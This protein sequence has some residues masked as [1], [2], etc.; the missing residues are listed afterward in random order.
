MKIGYLMQAGVPDVRRY[1]LS[2]PANHVAQVF[3]ELAKL[4]HHLRLL[5]VLDHRIWKS[6]DLRSFAPVTVGWADHR[7][8]RSFERG[9][10]RIQSELR[11]PYAALFEGVRFALACRQELSG[12]DLLYER[13]GWVGYG[14]SLAAQWLQ[15]PLILE[16]NGDHLTELERRGIAP[17]G[18]Q[19]RLSIAL[20]KSVTRRASHT[21]ATGEGHR[22]Q[23]IKRWSVD[24]HKLTVVD[25]GSEL[26]HLLSRSQ[27]HA[28]NVNAKG[29]G[30][31]TIAYSGGF[32]PWQ[33][34]TILLRAVQRTIAAGISVRLL[35][36]GSGPGVRDAA[37]MV[38]ELDLGRYV[39]FCGHLA[40]P[41]YATALA[42]ANIG[43]SPISDWPEYSGLKLMDYKA[44]G[45]A[46]IASGKEGQPAVIDHGRTGLIVP[47]GDEDA[48]YGALVRLSSDPE[49][50]TQMGR[51]ARM[52]AERL[53][54]WKN[55][56]ERLNELFSQVVRD[57]RG[58][59]RAAS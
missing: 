47:P 12:Y 40:A 11:L 53:H 22:R 24:P 23:H 44:A 54:S 58:K 35:L 49:L 14:G 9:I 45:L 29:S 25:N 51:A 41:E 21:V 59:Q 15:M 2:G 37:H 48:L 39:A 52:E 4:G 36:I 17:R 5:A 26:V 38:Q 10:R 27:L 19:R 34:T 18:M 31:R 32:D 43:V 57:Y 7:V 46:V 42:T 1:P 16:V 20:M 50:T 8:F 56:A 3:S 55:T 33:G 28:F 30:V 6:D 13:L